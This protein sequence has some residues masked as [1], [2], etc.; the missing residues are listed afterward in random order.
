MKK[1]LLYT[2]Q[3]ADK[4]SVNEAYVKYLSH[5]G[6]VILVMSSNN[7]ERV[8]A[9][10]DVL[11]L[12]GGADVDPMRY[13]EYPKTNTRI[14]PHFEYLDKFLLGE[15]LKTGKPI[16]GICRGLQTLNVAMGGSLYQHIKGHN[17]SEDRESCPQ[18][19]YTIVPGF[20]VHK[21]NSFHHQAIKRLAPNFTVLGWT[22]AY[23]KCDSLSESIRP[24]GRFVRERKDK[25]SSDWKI[26]IDEKT[27]KPE[28][29]YSFPEI[30]KHNSLPYIAFQYHPEEFNCPLASKLICQVLNLEY[31]P[32]KIA[33][34]HA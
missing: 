21:V 14:N 6:E 1:I 30:I 24:E 31:E 5:F 20:P 34:T 25:H 27:K 4:V 3:Y 10:A 26:V 11:A 16:I 15:W 8:I 29:Y 12:P 19:M 32:A 28:E 9:E 13:G 2:D 22:C 23:N 17:Q 33:K 7:M 18:T